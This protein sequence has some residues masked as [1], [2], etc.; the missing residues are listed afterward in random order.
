MMKKWAIAL[1]LLLLVLVAWGLLAEGNSI[2]I[3]I[4]GQEISGPFRG[5]VGLAGMMVATI[6]LFCAVILLAFVFA[7]I[8]LFLLGCVLLVGLVVT[9]FAF[10]FALLI[11]IPLA[12]VW[13][14]IAAIR[15][16]DKNETTQT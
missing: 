13:L 14:F 5:A 4:N 1:A 12:V 3:V 16:R 9:G 6:A 11:L 2:R 8:G 10:P 15:R 7:G